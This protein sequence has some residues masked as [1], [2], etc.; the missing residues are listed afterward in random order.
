ME[1]SEQHSKS[2]GKSCSAA[3]QTALHQL[4]HDT[5]EMAAAAATQQHSVAP[6]PRDIIGVVVVSCFMLYA[7]HSRSHSNKWW[8]PHK[9]N[10]ASWSAPVPREVVGR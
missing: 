4:R 5:T 1:Q 7:R 2:S 6:V 8:Q 10:E 3:R 9:Q